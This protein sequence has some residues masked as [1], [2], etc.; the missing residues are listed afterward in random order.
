MLFREKGG[1]ISN[2]LM[3]FLHGRLTAGAPQNAEWRATCFFPFPF[4]RWRAGIRA[5]NLRNFG[6]CS[7]KPPNI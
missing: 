4:V 1:E 6:I 7:P 2:L 5:T 3:K